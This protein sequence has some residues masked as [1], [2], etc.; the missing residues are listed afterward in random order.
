MRKFLL[1]FVVGILTIPAGAFAAAWR[2][3]SGEWRAGGKG[4]ARRQEAETRGQKL[5]IGNSKMENRNSTLESQRRDGDLKVTATVGG[6]AGQAPPLQ[7]T[8][9]RARNR[10]LT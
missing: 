2:K 7:M 4:E 3:K 5:E 9:I 6:A 8:S 10:R 1:G